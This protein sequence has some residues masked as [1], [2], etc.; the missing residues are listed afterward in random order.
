MRIGAN[1]RIMP[2]RRRSTTRAPVA[3][4]LAATVALAGCLDGAEAPH[5]E[6]PIT[7]YV[8]LPLR[9]PSGADG[10]DAADG[11]RLALS[12]AGGAAGDHEVSAVFL[13]GTED[14]GEGA[15]WTPAQVGR[16]ARQATRDASA[17]AYIGELE[18]G[19][20]RTSLPITNEARM[21][22]VSP[23]SAAEDLV[24]EPGTFDAVPTELQPSGERTFGRVVP[25]DVAQ[26]RA[27][28]AWAAELDRERAALIVDRSPFAS[29]VAR[30]F[31]EEARVAGLDAQ[32]VRLGRFLE[33]L[34]EE[35]AGASVGE[36]CALPRDAPGPRLPAGIGYLAGEDRRALAIFAC[37]RPLA[38]GPLV[39][40][41]AL[42][43]YAGEL[44]DEQPLNR[45]YLTS[46]AQ[47][48]SHLPAS[49]RDFVVRFRREHGREPGRYAAY[50]YEAMAVVLDS[51]ERAGAD[52]REVI[53]AFLATADRDSV[54]GA[55]S[56]E[57][58][59]ETTLDRMS[60]YRVEGARARPV[61]ELVP[62]R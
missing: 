52:R 14:R 19:A 38:G 45:I 1:I 32:R 10:R 21:L 4:A 11:A 15:R 31:A 50:G 47:D 27:G 40:T 26:A 46:A 30:A 41:D 2:I 48:P 39:G 60:V 62:G 35:R 29:T 22:Q 36:L 33:P 37:L 8:S 9:G 55:Y 20:T 58:T 49:G 7:V 13:D 57:G 3:L 5:P 44:P 28:A 12:E 24:R 42:L 17:I 59:G 61:S 54:L 6:D 16:N 25:S 53:E 51:I 43:P 23:G 34:G 18:S 56:I